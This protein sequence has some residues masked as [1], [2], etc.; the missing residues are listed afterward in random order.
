MKSLFQGKRYIF[1]W[2]R[3]IVAAV[4]AL[5]VTGASGYAWITMQ[6]TI[7]PYAPIS[8]TEAL[9]IG[10][11]H[12]S[13]ANDTFE[14]IRYMY[15]SGFN[16]AED[17][18]VYKVFCIYGKGIGSYDMQLAHTTNNGFIYS[19]YRATESPTELPSSV[20]SYTTH[21]ETPQTFY[22]T[23]G[24]LVACDSLNESGGVATDDYHEDTY[25]NYGHV[26]VNAEPVY[27]QTRNPETGNSLDD[28]VNYYI[29]KVDRNGKTVNDRETDVLCIAA[30][31]HAT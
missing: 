26:Q 23:L 21:E 8:A 16:V 3:L 4:F 15:F 14:D 31:T 19:I 13:I 10:A 2:L 18:Y 17:E 1:L 12:R 27:W 24:A 20:V 25:G 28:F 7:L 22:Y 11:G 5:C 9:Y 6:K 29:L 30:K